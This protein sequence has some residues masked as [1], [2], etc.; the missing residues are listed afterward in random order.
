VTHAQAR[1]YR[2]LLDAAAI[3][4]TAPLSL[5]E[6]PADFVAI[7]FYKMFGYPAGVGALVAR[8]EAL[9]SLRRRYFAGGTVQFVSVRQDML[10]RRTFGAAFEDGTPNFLA[11]PA[12]CDGL[13]WLRR[14]GMRRIEQHVSGLTAQLLAG[15][16]AL[17]DR[18]IVYG[19]LDTRA[20]GGVVAFNVRSGD[21][22]LPYEDVVDAANADGIAL[23]GGCFCN[24]GAAEQALDFPA[25]ETRE[26][27][28]G[29]FSI[30]R[31]RA[32]L[33]GRAVGAVRASMGVATSEHDV[34]KLVDF[35]A[36]LR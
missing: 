24:P 12:V 2:V 34:T 18:V 3:V 17:G 13:R 21:R 8:R 11:M 14:L 29:G 23:R 6:V 30:P 35:L 31:L 28:R 10:R 7:S 16:R 1:G 36:R 9:A 22:V 15:L 25:T 20:R 19:P 5:T 27:L 26:C 32:C 33:G 4:S